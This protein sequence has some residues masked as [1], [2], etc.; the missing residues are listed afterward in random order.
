VLS[1]TTSVVI[2]TGRGTELFPSPDDQASRQL[3]AATGAVLA[4]GRHELDAAHPWSLSPASIAEAPTVERL[5][6]PSPN[7]SAISA[8]V[9]GMCTGA[10][11]GTGGRGEAKTGRG[12]GGRGDSGGR[13]GM[14]T[15]A[16]SGG[17]AGVG[18]A[19]SA[20]GGAGVGMAGGIPVV[21]ACLRNAAAVVAWLL[22]NGYGT[23]A[24]PIGVIAAGEQW[25]DGSL[26]PAIEDL[27]GAGLV[28]T[29]LADAGCRLTPEATVAT[30]SVAGLPPAQ[31]ADLVRASTSGREL[32]VA[33]YGED[34]ELAVEVD[35]D[36][37]VPV[38]AAGSTS[39]LRAP[40][41]VR[42]VSP[43]A[44]ATTRAARHRRRSG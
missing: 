37:T 10:E 40:A 18:A 42:P 9:A 41:P 35:A 13:E 30:R 6:L 43:T 25:P 29:G 21:A 22:A 38:M 26:R 23:A 20:G 14:G 28:L 4:V 2:A 16:G 12:A 15:G 31:L 19:M 39:F 44:G 8:L 34:V 17:R 33:G 3:A 24:A 1:F 5:V 11:T 36:T 27:F 7:G 32:R